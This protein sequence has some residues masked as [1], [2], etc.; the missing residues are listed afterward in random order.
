[1]FSRDCRISSLVYQT[2][3]GEFHQRGNRSD[4]RTHINEVLDF[5]CY[6]SS[7]FDR[8]IRRFEFEDDDGVL[9]DCVN[10][11]AAVQVERREVP[12]RD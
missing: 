8:F 6:T 12:V 1:M 4:F 7:H 5:N 2:V 3:E 10:Y 9:R 11:Y